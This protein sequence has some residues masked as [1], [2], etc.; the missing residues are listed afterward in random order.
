[1]STPDT[2]NIG[3][4]LQAAGENLN[5]WGDP[6]LN[7]D[8]IIGS[9]LA[10]KWKA[11][12]INGDYTVSETNYST[13]NDTE[14][15]TI[16]LVAGTVAAAFNVIF[17]GRAKRI[18]IWNASGYTAT[19]KLA[20][21]TGF[22]LPTG[23]IALVATDGTTDFYNLSPN[24]GGVLVP[25]AGSLDIPSW[26]AVQTAIATAGLPATS[27][28]VLVSGT[29]TTA[30]YL[31]QKIT[32]QLSGLTTT[33]VSGLVSVT[34]AIINPSGNAQIALQV[35]GG[36]VAGYLPGGTKT[37]Q[38]TPVVGTEY[39][40][41][42]TTSSYTIN[43]SGMTTPQIGQKFYLNCFGAYQPFLLGTVN[44][45]TNLLLDAGSSAELTYSSASWGWN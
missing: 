21:T 29:D 20:A 39:N 2:N 17:P 23:R 7:N 28:A 19:C 40:C 36:Y 43:L 15:A 12:T 6:N 35:G 1:M 3:I 34:L 8:L 37:S 14:V 38:F 24:Y 41:D 10:S 25:T 22:S 18:L 31:G 4:K 26:S 11:L 33:Q 5:T 32:Q 44:G 27:G 9:N 30:G 45:L 13:T 42:F 16:K